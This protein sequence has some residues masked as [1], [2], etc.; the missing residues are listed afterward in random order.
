MKRN[1]DTS[2]KSITL[3]IQMC[4]IYRC[5]ISWGKSQT[6]IYVQIKRN[7]ASDLNLFWY[8]SAPLQAQDDDIII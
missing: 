7:F 1:T 6:I 5:I 8:F 4:K 2:S 3:M